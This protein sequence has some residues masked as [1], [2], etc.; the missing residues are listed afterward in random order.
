MACTGDAEQ[1]CGGGWALSVM[2]VGKCT[3]GGQMLDLLD[4]LDVDH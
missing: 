1:I 3:Q 4:L 2:Q